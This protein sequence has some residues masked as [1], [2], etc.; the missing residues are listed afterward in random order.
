MQREEGQLTFKS[1]Y[2]LPPMLVQLDVT[3]LETSLLNF[4]APANAVQIITITK[5]RTKRRIRE[6][7]GKK[8]KINDKQ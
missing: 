1:V 3:H 5:R 4:D 6:N 2:V 8:I 7:K